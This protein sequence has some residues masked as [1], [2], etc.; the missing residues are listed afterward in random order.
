MGRRVVVTGLG[1][2][3]A[4]G[5]DVP[6]FWRSLLSGASGVRA[7]DVIEGKPA[8]VP[9]VAAVDESGLRAACETRAVRRTERVTQLA[10][11]AAEQ[12][13]DDAALG[14]LEGKA[15]RRA[16]VILG[17]GLGGLLFQEEQMWKVL[18]TGE[19]RIHPHSVPRI[20]PTALITEVAQRRNLRGPGF[21]VSSACASAAHALGQAFRSIQHGEADVVLS[22]GAEAPISRFTLTAFS[23]LGVLARKP[24]TAGQACKPFDRNREGFVLGEGA[25]MLVLEEL[26]HA[27]ARGAR[28]YGEICGFG[29]SLGAHHAVAVRPDGEDAADAMRAALEDAQ[30]PP[31]AIAYVNAHGTGTVDNDV[32]ESRALHAVFGEGAAT[33]PI[34]SIKGVTGHTLGAAGALE[35]IATLL[36]LKHG[37]LPPS[38][39]CETRDEACAIGVITGEPRSTRG[40]YALSNSFGFGNINVTLALGRCSDD[41]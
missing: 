31:D 35:A 12:A 27:R 11:L 17:S 24:G 39:N 38:A 6:T 32:A 10:S 25:G 4:A 7:L 18:R 8:P 20:S 9:F 13:F 34:S 22:G 16:G 5:L 15:A 19:D 36:A 30:L 2:A 23:L 1:V 3:C 29:Q 28:I 26:D 14:P 21:V 41:P 40:R 37:Q 33:L